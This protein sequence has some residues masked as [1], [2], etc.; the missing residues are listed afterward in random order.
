ML[1]PCDG[2]RWIVGLDPDAGSRCIDRVISNGWLFG[3]V[4]LNVLLVLGAATGG[5]VW[6][7]RMP[8]PG[9]AF[10]PESTR[11]LR[12][13]VGERCG[14]ST[15]GVGKLMGLPTKVDFG[16]AAVSTFGA[17]GDCC[18]S[19]NPLAFAGTTLF[20]YFFFH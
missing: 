6:D 2:K 3:V 10:P 18:L 9:P 13:I 8:L 4:G 12:L 17:G 14:N 15:L 5:G 1:E 20:R 11:S 7:T 16:V 19:A